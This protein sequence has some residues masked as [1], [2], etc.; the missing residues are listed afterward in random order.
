VAA[1]AAAERVQR[2]PTIRVR[3]V[4]VELTPDQP[5]RSGNAVLSAV[6]A[7]ATATRP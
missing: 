5:E 4:E 6:R 2:L 1:Q 3:G 7:A